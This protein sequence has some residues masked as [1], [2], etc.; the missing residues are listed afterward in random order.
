MPCTFCGTPE[1]V[2]NRS[3]IDPTGIEF[4]V[5]IRIDNVRAPA[6]RLRG[7][8]C[9]VVHLRVEEPDHLGA[10]ARPDRVV[11]VFSKL[12]MHR[13]VA[14]VDHRELLGLRIVNE[15]LE[16]V[17]ARNRKQLRRWVVRSLFA[18]GRLILAFS[19][20]AGGP[21]PALLIEHHVVEAHL[22]GPRDFFAPRE[23]DVTLTGLRPAL[24]L[25]IRNQRRIAQRH[26]RRH[27]CIANGIECDHCVATVLFGPVNQTVCVQRRVPRIGRHDVM[28][29]PLLCRPVPERDDDVALDALRTRGRRRHFS[30]GNPIEPVGNHRVRAHPRT[31]EVRRRLASLDPGAQSLLRRFEPAELLRHFPCRLVADLVELDCGFQRGDPLQLVFDAFLF[32]RERALRWRLQ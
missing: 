27:P 21:E 4:A 1:R 16:V 24:L 7:V 31:E 22:R 29:E 13:A 30:G 25:V 12:E 15:Q 26:R 11:C 14:S 19:E 17:V 2:R 28:D 8:V 18:E 20:L 32:H 6:L 9:L 5:A 3:W 23:R 10:A